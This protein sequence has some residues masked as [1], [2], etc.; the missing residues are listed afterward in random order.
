MHSHHS[1]KYKRVSMSELLA[2]Y[3]R[4]I[5]ESSLIRIVKRKHINE[6]IEK[7]KYLINYINDVFYTQYKKYLQEFDE[8]NLTDDKDISIDF[9]N[10]ISEFEDNLS[11]QN[12][13]LFEIYNT[14]KF[15]SGKV[16]ITVNEINNGFIS[17]NIG[18]TEL[19]IIDTSVV[20]IFNV[21]TAIEKYEKYEKQNL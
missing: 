8:T 1:N 21:K 2:T 5:A 4:D 7:Y 16:A 20:F 3:I 12:K 11:T 6:E 17:N 13:E 14:L 18:R 19:F 10:F 15:Y 9:I